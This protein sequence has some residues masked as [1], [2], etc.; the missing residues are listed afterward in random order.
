[1]EGAAHYKG[2]RRNRKPLVELGTAR[3]AR[4]FRRVSEGFGG[5]GFIMSGLGARP[6]QNLVNISWSR[7]IHN[8]LN[9]RGVGPHTCPRRCPRK[10]TCCMKNEHFFNLQ[11]S[12]CSLKRAK[13]ARKC[14]TCSSLSLLKTRMSS[15][16]TTTHL[17][18]RGARTLFIT[19]VAIWQWC[20]FFIERGF[21]EGFGRVS[22]S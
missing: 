21:G 18:R 20:L 14:S 8:C 19:A 5:V 12:W 11:N 13:T 22:S 2:E 3:Q 4:G 15:I 6:G 9:F 7:P 17:P 16:Y 1:V 10:A